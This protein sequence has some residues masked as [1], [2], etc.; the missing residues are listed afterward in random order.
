MGA[1]EVVLVSGEPGIGKSRLISTFLRTVAN[2]PQ[3]RLRHF[4]S[5]HHEESPLHPVISWL[6]SAASFEGEDTATERREK[7]SH[8]L[9]PSGPSPEELLLFEQLLSIAPD[10]SEPIP[11]VNPKERKARTLAALVRQ[12]YAIAEKQPVLIIWEDIHWIDPTSRELLDL[13][14]ANSSELSL[15]LVVTFRP[16]FAPPWIAQAN[17]TTIVLN[18]LRRQENVDLIKAVSGGKTFPD[19]LVIQMLERTDG[20]PLFVEE[21][22]KSLLESG[23]L[24][25]KDNSLIL[26]QALPPRA[27]PLSLHALLLARLDR[28]N[29]VREVAQIAAAIGREFSYDLLAKVG[30]LPADTLNIGLDQLQEA[31]L[32]FARGLRPTATYSFKHALVQD[33]AYSTLLKS[34]RQRSTHELPQ[35]LSENTPKFQNGNPKLSPVMPRRPE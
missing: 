31:G 30:D 23:V 1:G 33:A 32:I 35:F 12:L 15:L 13:L 27:I 16:E 14:I 17:V 3:I 29:N 24:R 11:D 7:L 5:P 18:R 28:R 34:R 26:A 19:E 8:L 21:L 25:E 6:E 10:S 2:E 4:C 22:T 20:V 9:I